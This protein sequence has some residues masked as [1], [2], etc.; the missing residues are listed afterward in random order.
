MSEESNRAFLGKGLQYPFTFQPSTGG[1]GLSTATSTDVELIRQSILQI[2]FTPLG[3]RFFRPE[4]GS[5]LL[6][7]VFEP[8]DKV[9]EGLARYYIKDALERWEKRVRLTEYRF[10]QDYE[11][12]IMWVEIKFKIVSTNVEGNLVFPFYRGV[13]I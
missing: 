11:N 4:F 8:N 6:T 7:L 9:L 5:R 3:E 13:T 10:Y 1:V 2:L 12:H